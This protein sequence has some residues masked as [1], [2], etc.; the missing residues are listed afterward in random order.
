MILSREPFP[1]MMR[2]CLLMTSLLL[3][4]TS[5]ILAQDSRPI[6]LSPRNL[7]TAQGQKGAEQ[8]LD[9]QEAAGNPAQNQSSS[10]QTIF[11]PGYKDLY[12][13]AQVIIDLKSD[14]ALEA[15][16]YYDMYGNDSIRIYAGAPRQWRPLSVVRTGAFRSWKKVEL[17]DTARYLKLEF[18]SN[19]AQIAEMLLYGHDLGRGRTS[20]AAAVNREPRSMG[21]LIGLNGFIDDPLPILAAAGG[22]LR[23]YHRWQWTDNK[24]DSNYRGYPSED[25]AFNPAWVP[26]WDFDDYYRQLDERGVTVAPVVQTT[27]PYLQQGR[28]PE[29]K[30]IWPG[31]NPRAP[32]SYKAHGAML[33]QYA[34]RYGSQKVPD[35]LLA[36]RDDQE[37]KSGLGYLRYLENWNEP[38]K[39]WHGEES[40]F[41]PFEFAAMSSADYDG[42]EGS[43]GPQV[44][45]KNADS[46][47]KV[48]MGGITSLNLDYVKAM[49]LWSDYNRSSGFPADVLN[50]HHY[51]HNGEESS[52]SQ[53]S[54]G[55]SP[56]ADSLKKRLQSLVAYRDKWLPE[57]EI[58]L[59]E[60]GYDTHPESVQAAPSIGPYDN[61]EVQGQWLVRSY[62]E[63]AASGID[64]AFM[65][66]SRDV[67]HKGSRKYSSSGLTREKWNDHRPKKSF[68]YVAGLRRIL[69][70]FKFAEEIPSGDSRVNLYK[71]KHRRGD[72][73][74]YAVW[75]NTSEA[76][77]ISQFQLPVSGESPARL[78]QLQDDQIAPRDTALPVVNEKLQIDIGERPVFIKTLR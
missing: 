11:E 63:I 26:Y 68:Y 15:L 55:I 44:G 7:F 58:W 4:C 78:Y 25:L 40:M 13:P 47:M 67:N 12:L 3:G 29:T 36:L 69:G 19:Q 8:L 50:F 22:S 54:Q 16:W 75:C 73:I 52:D 70:N 34:A 6:D 1:R 14:H 10:P 39:W 27:A 57:R 42:H 53:P 43:L 38:D 45:I 46:S 18:V 30:P 9:E 64:R 33:Y 61:Q 65:Y 17:G 62:L 74:A 56:E 37:V 21:K 49:K 59:S 41:T 66:M 28:N 72:S 35:S 76:L 31:A 24:V 23:E 20:P 48:V 71:F 77:E 2:K 5:L 60:F 32:A 51:C